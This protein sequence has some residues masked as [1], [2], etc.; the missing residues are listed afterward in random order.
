MNRD[1]VNEEINQRLRENNGVE[2]L[3]TK[4]APF[5][6]IASFSLSIH[7][8]MNELRSSSVVPSS[9]VVLKIKICY[10]YILTNNFPPYMWPPVNGFIARTSPCYTCESYCN[11]ISTRCFTVKYRNSVLLHRWSAAT[12]PPSEFEPMRWPSNKLL[13]A[14][15]SHSDTRY[16]ASM[17]TWRQV[18]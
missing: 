14:D 13:K 6:M 5:V 3:L 12:K 1:R 2:V 11:I 18:P 16:N 17:V 15:H 7:L 8:V 4:V 10:S 9:T